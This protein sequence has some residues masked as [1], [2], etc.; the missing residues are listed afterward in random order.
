[1][2][3]EPV[4]EGRYMRKKITW[5]IAAILVVLVGSSAC[6]RLRPPG[7]AQAAALAL[8]R[9]DHAP[10]PGHNAWVVFWLLD[11]DVPA[12]QLDAVYALERQHLFDWADR[13]PPDASSVPTYDPLVA[14]TY[15]KRPE[16]SGDDRAL[17]CRGTDTDCLAKVRV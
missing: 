2:G 11:Y 13:L 6:G 12:D 7:K 5:F 10:T 1:M 16:I 9:Q 17:L 14:E 8:L 15:P 4:D 3:G